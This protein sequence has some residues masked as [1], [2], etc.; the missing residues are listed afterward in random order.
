MSI[1][2]AIS[3][4]GSWNNIFPIKRNFFAGSKL[5]RERVN[6][7]SKEGRRIIVSAL[8]DFCEKKKD[9]KKDTKESFCLLIMEGT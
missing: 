7:D 3:K 1:K 9:R 6:R 8:I 4:N 2:S 5:S